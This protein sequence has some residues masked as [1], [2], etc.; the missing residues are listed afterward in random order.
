MPPTNAVEELKKAKDGLD[1]YPDILRYAREGFAAITPEDFTRLRWYGFY[2]QKPKEEGH[3]MM[4]LKLPNGNLGA[5]QLREIG[6]VAN[7]FGRGLADITT[8]QNFQFHWLKVEQFPEILRRLGAVG[9]T[10][11]GACGDITR[12][13]VGCPVAGIEQ[14]EFVN[15][16]PIAREIHNY[17]IGN[18]KYSNLPRKYK[19]SISGCRLHCAQ[20]DIN[21]VGLY[22]AEWTVNGRTERGFGLKV[23]GGLSTKP[24]FAADL[25]VFLRPEEVLPVVV[26]ITGIFRDS[27]IL[28]EN[29]SRARLKF[30]LHDPKIG[31]GPEKFRTM[32]EER[33]GYRLTDGGPY[34]IPKHTELDHL[35]ICPQKQPGLWYVGVGVTVG[36][37]NGDLLQRIADTAEEFSTHGSLRTTNKQNFLITNVPESRL[38]ALKARLRELDLDYEP[39]VFKKGVVSCTG[40]EFCNLAITETKEFGRRVADELTARFPAA[41]RMVRIHFSGCPNNCGQAWIGD[42]GLRGGLTKVDG[43]SIECYDLL[44]GGTTGA[45]RAFG[46]TAIKKVPKDKVVDVVA[47]LYEAFLGWS[48]NG[49]TFHEFVKAHTLEQLADIGWPDRP[50]GAAVAKDEE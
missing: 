39:S 11:L 29:R 16:E 44:A 6:R 5:N 15:G 12:N 31:I 30:L 26:A 46:E 45:A 14:D 7:D 18:K 48:N 22:G 27:E 50:K 33:I 36:R 17:F 40:I 25:G 20:P 35:G 34:P 37:M 23:G 43:K 13:V 1:V 47:N 19:I 10:T 21:D 38:E 3:F 49:E 28:R 9:I 24:Y 2:Q 4:R 8:R 42:I 41:P 32:V